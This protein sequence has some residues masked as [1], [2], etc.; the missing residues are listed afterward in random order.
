VYV[1]LARVK[2]S[3][4]PIGNATIVAEEMLRWLREIEGFEGLLM[5]SREGTTVGLTFWQSRDVAERHHVARMQFLERMTSIA[6]VQVEEMDD[7]E[8][9]FAQLGPRMTDFAG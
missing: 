6:G 5:L 2:T 3:D 8:V 1:S 9:T 7:F 4:Q